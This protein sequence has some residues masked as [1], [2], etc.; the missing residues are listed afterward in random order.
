MSS[1]ALETKR[2]APGF[3]TTSLW[4]CVIGIEA[5]GTVIAELLFD[6]G[7]KDVGRWTATDR[8]A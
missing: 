8:C 6:V 1:S 2:I 7:V 5:A 3:A 4:A